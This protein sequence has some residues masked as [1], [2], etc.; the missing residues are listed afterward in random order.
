MII[1]ES[2]NTSFEQP[3]V[4]VHP[5]RCISIIDLGTQKSTYE[6][7]A[8]IKHQLII[9]WELSNELMATGEFAGKPFTVSKFYTASLHEKSGLRKDLAAWRGRDFTPDEL[10]GFDMKTILGKACMLSV[11][12]TDKGKAKVTTVMGI[13]KGMTVPAQVNTSF[14][15]SLGEFKASDFELLPNGFKKMVMESKE[16][17]AIV[18]RP[19]PSRSHQEPEAVGI[20]DDDIPFATSSM[21][22]DMTT[23]KQR[24]LARYDY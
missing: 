21:Y 2:S 18:S 13:P 10:H 20:E 19:A 15:F 24:K 6:G 16:Y 9:R 4:G 17:Q 23:S 8:Q 12:L 1:S 11:G 3:P 5:A 22:Y 7:E 14:N